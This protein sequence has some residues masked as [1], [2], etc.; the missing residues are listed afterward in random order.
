MLTF[1]KLRNTVLNKTHVYLPKTPKKQGVLIFVNSPNIDMTKQ[2]IMSKALA[3]SSLYP[4]Y[5]LDYRYKVKLFGKS[6]NEKIDTTK[7]YK[8]IKEDTFITKT[9]KNIEAYNLSNTFVDL[10]QYNS[11][12]NDLRK[13][14]KGILVTDVYLEYLN[15]LVNNY[16]AAYS[17]KIMIFN[18]DNST[19]DYGDPSAYK[20]SEVTEPLQILLLELHRNLENFKTLPYEI[21]LIKGKQSIYINPAVCD[22][23]SFVD[24]RKNINRFNDTNT[25]VQDEDSTENSVKTKKEI[26]IEKIK[27]H[28]KDKINIGMTKYNF[29]GVDLNDELDEKVDD[30]IDE[31]VDELDDEEL[32]DDMLQAKIEKEVEEKLNKDIEFITKLKLSTDDIITNN[33]KAS[34]KRNM[35]LAEKQAKIKIN[36]TG[37]TIEEILKESKSKEIVP[38]KLNINTLNPYMKELKLP[39]F[40]KDYND[41]LFKKDLINNV[42]CFKDMRIPAYVLDIKTEDTST[43]FDKKETYTIKLETGDRERHTLKFDVPKFVDD[44][45]MYLGGNKKNIISQLVLKPVVKTGPDTVQFC[46]NYNKIFMRRNGQR[47][48]PKL[49]R[50]K[51]ALE[52]HKGYNSS[53]KLFFKTGNNNIVN[54]KYKTNMEFDELASNYMMITMNNKKY[55]FYFNI[56][57]IKNYIVQNNIK[58]KEDD[59]LLPVCIKDGKEVL[60]LD[61]DSNKIKGT[62]LEFADF[63]IQCTTEAIKDFDIELSQMTSG[64][65]F[66]YTDCTIMSKRVP[67]ILLLSYLEG[68]TTTLKKAEINCEFSDK[69]KQLA[70]NEKN[71]KEVIQ[72]ADGFLYYDRYP[73]RNSLLLNAMSLLPTK[74]YNYADFDNK[75]TYLDIFDQLYG[76]KM[77]LN[78]FEN[79]Y[80]LFIDPITREVLEDL[81]LPTGFSELMLHGNNL[82]EDNQFV[83]ENN[84]SLYRLRNNE[85]VNAVMYQCIADAYSRYR[86]TAGNKRPEKISVPQDC[87]IKGLLMLNTV[88]DYSTLNPIL[89]AEKLRAVSFK[90]LSG[91]NMDRAYTLE[92]RAY[93]K[94]MKGIIAMSSPPSGSVGLVRQLAM[95]ANITSARGY[96]KIADDESELTSTNMF[97]PSELMTPFCAQYDDSPRVAMVTTQTKHV[98]PCKGYSTLLITN[99]ADRALGNVI[100]N[101]FV[102]KAKEDGKVIDIDNDAGV[103]IVQYKS[104]KKDVIETYEKIYKNGGGGF[105]MINKLTSDLKVGNTF[106]AGQILASDD[107]FFQR[108]GLDE[109]IYRN[110]V[111]AKIA[112]AAGYFTYEDSA[113][114]TE[115]L[116]KDLA[117]EVAM[118]ETFV[119]G[120]NSN[121]EFF[122]KRGQHVEVGDPLM[123][124]DESYS[125][126]T[127]NKLLAS[128]SDESRDDVENIGRVPLKAKHSGIIEDVKV[129]Y[130]VEMD[131]LSPSLQKFINTIN[132]PLIKR[133]KAINKHTKVSDTNII[134]EPTRKV[135]AKYG[136]VKGVDVGEGVLI[137]FYIN[138]EVDCGIGDKIIQMNALKSVIC[139]IIPKGK[140]PYSEFRPDEEIGAFLSPISFLAR[141]TGS[142]LVNGWGN[143]VLI[144]TKRKM[145]EIYES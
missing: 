118:K 139:E 110:G 134:L 112:M 22:D 97:C 70:P 74:D 117:T 28:Y 124:F 108:A 26:K 105:Y 111:L 82:L 99:G 132:A 38:M 76:N 62:D 55:A 1:D 123:I 63:I 143:K 11:Y 78:A 31:V 88:E 68:F 66:I 48:S 145:K 6:V 109:S 72:F 21:L 47:I 17:R 126:D 94:T 116:S 80:D 81:N 136:K 87:V 45:Y 65:R 103:M 59:N 46:T 7:I 84:M 42:N 37:Q 33:S 138:H 115:K 10:G 127:I 18:L 92:K 102:F 69:R 39:N 14:R 113:M 56:E 133:E 122:A 35:L 130:T 40:C 51:K 13:N 128:L 71:D 34:T 5:F 20:I 129:Y 85:V 61:T 9:F 29:N 73:F 15:N 23:K 131:E 141:M 91:M 75:E 60:Y 30:M 96:L 67:T 119:L 44:S 89:E 36:K 98:V 90:G 25:S 27:T 50:L 49:E 41:K 107:K 125:D 79:F 100:S 64:K 142:I 2:T 53:A 86:T 57:E 114:I 43:E 16:S 101:D 8:E 135:D 95:D 4:G 104:G 32:D 52:L 58:F 144:E 93:D 3:N 12:F 19:V 54:G 24:L 106:K 140:E 120:K 83:R 137:E 77:I 121:V